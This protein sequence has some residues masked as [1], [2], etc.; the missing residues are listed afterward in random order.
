MPRRA[1]LSKP[2]RAAS[3]APTAQ[4]LAQR[5]LEQKPSKQVRVATRIARYFPL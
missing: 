3:A 4:E 5:I 1:A 2:P